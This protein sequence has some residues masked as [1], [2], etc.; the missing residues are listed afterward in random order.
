MISHPYLHELFK[1]C[2][3]Y[4][5]GEVIRK[6]HFHFPSWKLARYWAVKSSHQEFRILRS[7]WVA[8]DE[9]KARKGDVLWI[10]R[11]RKHRRSYETSIL[12]EI[13][14][15]DFDVNE[16]FYKYRDYRTPFGNVGGITYLWIWGWDE[17]L[18]TQQPDKIVK[19]KIRYGR[20]RLLP[21]EIIFPIVKRRMEEIGFH[22]IER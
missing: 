18:N 4:D 1:A 16:V 14:T 9:P 22:L 10:L 20:V 17:I 19:H 11:K 5:A 15:G 3:L 21:L 6:L 13:K 2:L 8:D 12:H 7:P